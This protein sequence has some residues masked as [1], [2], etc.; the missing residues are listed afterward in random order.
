VASI[1]EQDARR[2]AKWRSWV[3]LDAKP[4]GWD[5]NLWGEFYGLQH[6]RDMGNGYKNALEG[7]PQ[8]ARDT[9]RYLTQWILRNHIETQA[10]AI[11]RIADRS[12]RSDSVA[13]GRML[14]DIAAHPHILDV[15]PDLA[16]E[17][18]DRMQVAAAK[19]VTFANKVVA[20]FDE[21]HEAASRGINM[22]DLDA[23][24]DLIADIWVRWFGIVSG[25][26]TVSDLPELGWSN[27]IRLH[28]RNGLIENPGFIAGK[29]VH[30]LGES[31][32]R[33][34]LGVLRLS[35][36]DRAALIGRLY[37]RSESRQVAEFLMDIE[38]DPDDLVRLR[39]IAELE[40]ALGVG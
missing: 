20:H 16:T 8:E 18:A 37:G 33:E 15:D 21:D 2:L 34:L 13:L 6:R 24:V 12:T 35:P 31:A 25:K 5:K 26:G 3:D 11:R 7:S 4:K 28:R 10:L 14:D 30:T 1:S 17:D 29:I 23:A 22:E 19:V 9:A 40:R 32:A 38:A 27:M 36:E 39:L